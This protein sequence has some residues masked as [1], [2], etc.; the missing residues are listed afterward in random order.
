LLNTRPEE[1]RW[2]RLVSLLSEAFIVDD[3]K[4]S[5]L[6]SAGRHF[7]AGNQGMVLLELNSCKEQYVNVRTNQV[8][9]N[10][11]T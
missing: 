11:T 7:F 2:P 6:F 3:R 1:K 4:A 5:N 9:K 8:L 10:G